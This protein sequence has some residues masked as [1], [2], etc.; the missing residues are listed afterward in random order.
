MPTMRH[1]DKGTKKRY[2]GIQY[3]PDGSHKMVFKGL[4]NVRS[5]WTPLARRVQQELYEKIFTDQPY[6]EYLKAVLQDLREG[7]LDD[8]LVYRKRL[9]RP[10]ADYQKNKPP[11]IQAAHKLCEQLAKEG[12]PDNISAG[13]YI[14][15]VIT[16][17]G[18]EPARYRHSAI[19]YQHY[20]DK[21]LLPVIDTILVF[22]NQDFES[23][24][25]PQFKLF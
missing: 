2:A 22:L 11:Q 24:A 25:T 17:N 15:Y 8:E 21:Q 4:E 18:P 23:M 12:K 5:D 14:E 6:L 16:V 13:T 7:V 3:Q 19:D 20:T 9:R 10:L 1:S